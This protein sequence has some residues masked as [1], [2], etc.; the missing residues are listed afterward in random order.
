M[1]ATPVRERHYRIAFEVGHDE[2]STQSASTVKST[3]EVLTSNFFTGPIG[4]RPFLQIDW[5][6]LEWTVFNGANEDS[7]VVSEVR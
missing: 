6:I 1:P 2:R 3:V 4:L 5:W 7:V